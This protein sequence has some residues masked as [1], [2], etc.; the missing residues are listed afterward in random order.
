[1]ISE[2]LDKKF[3]K[4]E[5][6]QLLK[7]HKKSSI[8]DVV[9]FAV[10][11][12]CLI[13]ISFIPCIE[14]SGEKFYTNYLYAFRENYKA[15]GGNS[16]DNDSDQLVSGRAVAFALVIEKACDSDNPESVELAENF[17]KALIA[18]SFLCLTDSEEEFN[19]EVAKG[20]AEFAELK[21]SYSM[22]DFGKIVLGETQLKSN[23]VGIF[24]VAGFGNFFAIFV[25]VSFLA[26]CL[27]ETVGFVF[28]VIK[29]CA[30]K[31]Y[32]QYMYNKRYVEYNKKNTRIRGGMQS[33]SL[34][35][36][37]L[38]TIFYFCSHSNTKFFK[39]PARIFFGAL[40]ISPLFYVML[41]IAAVVFIL[42]VINIFR[43]K[44]IHYWMCIHA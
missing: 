5:F 44:N 25:P 43:K 34:F 41:G 6:K 12:L 40:K 2:E 20:A 22:V 4:P 15:N 7:D 31:K 39:D 17:G 42:S 28:S 8:W 37:V 13:I 11:L 32:T 35:F 16:T 18:H 19:S 10:S 23:G 14:I 38:F 1:M 21:L 29:L 30:N 36:Y 9:L 33:L 24:T 3:E 27:I 26:V